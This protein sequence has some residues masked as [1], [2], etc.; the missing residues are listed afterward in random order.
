LTGAPRPIYNHT[1][2]SRSNNWA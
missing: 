1:Q 2:T